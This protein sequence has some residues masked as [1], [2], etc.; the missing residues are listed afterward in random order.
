[1]PLANIPD[2]SGKNRRLAAGT[3]SVDFKKPWDYLY[4]LS[5][6]SLRGEA[7]APTN[8]IWWSLLYKVRTYFEKHND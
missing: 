8:Q 1:L 2:T 6:S 7:T 5:A 3:L 4:N